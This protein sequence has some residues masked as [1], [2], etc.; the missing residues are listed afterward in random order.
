M[1][2]KNEWHPYDDREEHDLINTASA[3]LLRAEVAIRALREAINQYALRARE[4]RRRT[5]KKEDENAICNRCNNL[6]SDE[7]G[8][9]S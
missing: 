8:I 6:V 3:Q 5:D 7:L 1:D 2:T 4:I 9:D